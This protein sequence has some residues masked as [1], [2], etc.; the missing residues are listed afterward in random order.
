MSYGRIILNITDCRNPLHPKEAPLGP[1]F[2]FRVPISPSPF[3]DKLGPY[4]VLFVYKTLEVL[5][6][7]GSS[8]EASLEKFLWETGLSV[9][10]VVCWLASVAR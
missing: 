8:G 1:H 9:V 3:H 6:C 7:Q 2:C 5:K 4:L 10:S